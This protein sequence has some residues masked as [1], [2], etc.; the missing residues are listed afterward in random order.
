MNFVHLRDG[1]FWAQRFTGWILLLAASSI[2]ALGADPPEAEQAYQA[3][4]T[5]FQLKF[6][7]RAGKELAEF[8]EKFPSSPKVP[9]AILLQARSL[10]ELKEF[11]AVVNLLNRRMDAAGPL[12]DHFLL[13]LAEAELSGQSYPSAAKR[14]Q[15]LLSTFTNSTVRLQASYGQAWAHFKMRDEARTIQLLSDPNGDFQRA[16]QASTNDAL[17]VEGHLLLAE[18]NS[19]KK[20]YRTAEQILTELAVRNPAPELDWRRQYL[21]SLNALADQRPEDALKT[22]TNLVALASNTNLLNRPVLH[23][24]SLMLL[25]DI[26]DDKNPAAAIKTY[27]QITE[28]NGIPASQTQQALLKIIDLLVSQNQF[29]NAV[30]R[31]QNLLSQ[32]NQTTPVD[33]IYLTMGDLYLKQYFGPSGPTTTSQSR[34]NLALTNLLYRAKANYDLVISGPTNGIHLA[35]AHLNRAWCLWEEAMLT[36]AQNKFRESQAAFQVAA[37]RSIAP[38]DQAIAHFK[39]A[40]CQFQQRDFTNA[41]GN[42]RLLID[43]HGDVPGVKT[44]WFDQA[45][46]QIIR[47]SL[48]NSDTASARSALD[49]IV[50]GSPSGELAARSVLNYAAALLNRG[51]PSEAR[52]ARDALH[53][54]QKRAAKSV[55]LPE[56]HLAIARSFVVETNWPAAIGEY[57][58]WLARFTNHTAYP[59]AEFD[60]ARAYYRA[61]HETNALSSFT[62]FVARFATHPLAPLA[63]LWLGDYFYNKQEFRTAEENYQILLR[64]TNAVPA[65]LRYE[66]SLR[67]AQAALLRSESSQARGYLTNLINTLDRD[68]NRPADIEVKAWF[69]LGDAFLNDAQATGPT[70]RLE[71]FEKALAPFERIVTLHSTN[72]MAPRALAKLGDCNLQLASLHTNRYEMA[73]TN[74][75]QAMISPLA[76]VST[77]SQAEIGLGI[78]REKLAELKLPGEQKRLRELALENYLNVLLGTRI[79][80]PKGEFADPFWV[81]QAGQLA[82]KL[83]ESLRMIPQAIEVYERLLKEF[84]QL[85]K[86]QPYLARKLAELKQSQAK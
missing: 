36:G 25:A 67:A 85:R 26:Q 6:F 68:T 48:E 9:E 31:L 35:K 2:L 73:I 42:Y 23:A 7:E 20:E 65:R 24:N 11:L 72:Q 69:V 30:L 29:T 43:R 71:S 58:R 38:E 47:A 64:P 10:F 50:D 13:W 33:L 79:A 60:K 63:Q 14:Y 37:E 19:N 8:V 45:L 78:A 76:D 83:A 51:E 16:A 62:N 80:R 3:A 52:V 5:S 61:G 18:A 70:N 44:K 17:V 86:S 75:Y 27:G 54:F 15:E 74:Y 21:L 1:L 59:Q 46:Y 57:E 28:L 53:S 34:T 22:A 82:G 12:K 32:T 84:P 55:W 66:A 40:D 41:V 39:L 56:V 81:S 49:Q 4:L 77:R